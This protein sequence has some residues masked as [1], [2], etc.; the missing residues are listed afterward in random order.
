MA[1]R[2]FLKKEEER[3]VLCTREIRRGF[4]ITHPLDS[5]GFRRQVLVTAIEQIR[6]RQP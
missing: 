4:G 1:A 5:A 6:A 3:L 2:D